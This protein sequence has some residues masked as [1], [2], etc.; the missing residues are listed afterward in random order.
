MDMFNEAESCLNL[1][2][3]IMTTRDN[4]Y[5]CDGLTL[6]TDCRYSVSYLYIESTLL[7]TLSDVF[8]YSVFLLTLLS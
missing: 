4:R 5:I 3:F 8:F 2:L 7:Y 1:R 6:L